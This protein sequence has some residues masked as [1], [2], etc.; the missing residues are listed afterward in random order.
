M[1]VNGAH[2]E[3]VGTKCEIM[4]RKPEGSRAVGRTGRMY[5]SSQKKYYNGSETNAA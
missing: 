1:G 3:A 4:I 5:Y 2:M